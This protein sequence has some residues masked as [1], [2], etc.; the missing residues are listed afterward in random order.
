MT[1][2]GVAIIERGLIGQVYNR[3]MITLK[4]QTR[5]STLLEI[6]VAL[7]AAHVTLITAYFLISQICSFLSH[8]YVLS[9]RPAEIFVK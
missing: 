8:K 6:Q 7:I 4:F 9:D 2:H 5:F 3:L 1:I